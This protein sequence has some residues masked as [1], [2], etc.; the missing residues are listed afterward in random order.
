MT[1]NGVLLQKEL[2]DIAKTIHKSYI[3]TGRNNVTEN[4][5]AQNQRES[6]DIYSFTNGLL[7]ILCIHFNIH[8][9]YY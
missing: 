6:S 3:E 2:V 1:E 7:C 4:N 8:Y 9:Y 5:K